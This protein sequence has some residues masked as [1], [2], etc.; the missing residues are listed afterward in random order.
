MGQK[1]AREYNATFKIR[2]GH[3]GK[4]QAILVPRGKEHG[5]PSITGTYGFNL[6]S[7]DI[8]PRTGRHVFTKSKA[9]YF[10]RKKAEFKTEETEFNL[11]RAVPESTNATRSAV[12]DK[13]QAKSITE[14]R[15]GEAERNGG[16]GTVELDLTVE[17]QAEGKFIL[18]GARPG[19]DGTYKIDG[20]HHKA[21]RSGGSTTS[22]DLK[23]P[24]GGAGKDT[25][26]K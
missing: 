17:A 24:Q 20:V 22:L 3:G 8:T 4:D 26:K 1:L 25:R 5:L 11:D 19:I 13:A 15:K 10:D 23:H 16:D 14:A 18:V 2:A 6:I 21:S 7:W 12:H 9:K